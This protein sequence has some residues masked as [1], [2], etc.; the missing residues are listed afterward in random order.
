MQISTANGN[1][2]MAITNGNARVIASAGVTWV[3]A[4]TALVAGD[5]ELSIVG[6]SLVPYGI[7]AVYEPGHAGNTTGDR[8]ELVVVGVINEATNAAAAYAISIDWIPLGSSFLWD[9]Q[10]GDTQTLQFE[11]RNWRL[12]ASSVGRG[13]PAYQAI[14][15]SA[16][17]NTNSAQASGIH[18]I[19]CTVTNGGYTGTI[20]LPISGRIAGDRC[21]IHFD[22]PANNPVIQVFNNTTGGTNLFEWTG[23]GNA[24]SAWA[25]FVFDGAAFYLESAGF[26]QS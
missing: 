12:I 14:A 11:K 5:A 6:S 10:K 20:S 17:G 25:V 24:I 2:T 18:S 23:D 16:A 8:W 26:V 1:G 13:L 19:K 3:A 22:F 9:P 21:N 4:Q 7:A 15:I